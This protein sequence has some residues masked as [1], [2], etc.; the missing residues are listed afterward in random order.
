MS[1]TL[2]EAQA[3]AIKI[4]QFEPHHITLRPDGGADVDYGYAEMQ[5]Y[6]YHRLDANGHIACHVW[7]QEREKRSNPV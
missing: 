5:P 6:G 2:Q 3:R 1:L 7:C 4:W